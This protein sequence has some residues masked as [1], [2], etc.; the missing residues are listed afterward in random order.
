MA[1]EWIVEARSGGTCVVRVVHSLFASTDDW[2]GQLTS[3]ES[4]WPGFFRILRLYLTRF[5]GL[6]CASFRVMAF[7]PGPESTAW[8]ALTGPLGLDGLPVGGAI[9]PAAGA[10]PLLG[11]I[12]DQG[13]A[14]RFSMLRLE[15]PAPGI[16]F[17]NAHPMGGQICLI[18][19]FYFYGDQAAQTTAQHEPLWQ[20]WIR[21]RFP[22]Q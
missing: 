13:E 19:S 5:R 20:A 15:Q 4:G 10:P 8:A 17:L 7:A 6:P 2:D 21:A 9:A 3:V 14:M 16:A 22:S 1:T 11:V 12:E 18:L